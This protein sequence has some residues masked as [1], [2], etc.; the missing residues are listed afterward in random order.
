MSY[1]KQ[2]IKRL[3]L[4]WFVIFIAFLAGCS[5]NDDW[6]NTEVTTP[7][8]VLDSPSLIF[9]F[10][11]GNKSLSIQLKNVKSWEIASTGSDWLD[12]TPVSG[13]AENSISLTVAAQKSSLVTTRTATITLTV[14]GGV[15][16]TLSG[17]TIFKVRQTPDPKIAQSVSYNLTNLYF[18]QNNGDAHRNGTVCMTYKLCTSGNMNPAS[19]GSVG[20]SFSAAGNVFSFDI[21]VPSLDLAGLP[22]AGDYFVSNDDKS[23]VENTFDYGYYYNGGYYGWSCGTFFQI[24]N[25]S[26]A[27]TLTQYITDGSI[28]IARNGEFFTINADVFDSNDNEILCTYA[29]KLEVFDG[30]G[31]VERDL[32]VTSTKLVAGSTTYVKYSVILPEGYSPSRKYP[33][34][35][36]LHGYGGNNNSWLDDGNAKLL[37]SNA[38]ENGV[39][40]GFVVIM[41]DGYNA[42]YCNGYQNNYQY[43]SFF[44]DEFI[45]FIES[46]Y[47]I[48][49]GARAIAGLSMGGFGTLYFSLLHP[50]MFDLGYAMSPALGVINNINL[51]SL[52]AAAGSGNTSVPEIIV[53]CGTSDYVV[54]NASTFSSFDNTLE[55]NGFTHQLVLDPG[56]SHTWD[57]WQ[58]CYPRVMEELGKLW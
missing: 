5:K 13:G 28:K 45:P 7:S 58:L 4:I 38:I 50:E 23:S 1:I 30:Y 56:Y 17:T 11:G 26:G 47:S 43:M 2:H 14:H 3:K 34:L 20:Y 39:V 18:V 33:V 32:T 8:A 57:Y 29:G 10:S 6:S 19:N 40:P 25:S 54:Y 24:I 53:A 52:A 49:T 37:T 9:D 21:N 42:F 36:L 22:P 51:N 12:I 48:D 55:S 27:I 16:G 41:P 31:T 35:Y 46:K 15:K 44:Y